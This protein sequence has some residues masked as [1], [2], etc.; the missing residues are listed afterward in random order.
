MPRNAKPKPDDP[1]QSKRFI[2][3]A[4]A[5]GVDEDPKA[6]ERAFKAVTSSVKRPLRAAKSSKP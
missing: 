3:A 6:F 5:V 4:K 2:E 1:A